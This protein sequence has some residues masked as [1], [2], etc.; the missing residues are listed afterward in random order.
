[1]KNKIAMSFLT[2]GL[3]MSGVCLAGFDEGMGAANRGDYA[4]ALKEW[5]PLADQGNALAQKSLGEMCEN[6]WGV[7]QD[8]AQAAQWY[9][10][11]AEQGNASAQLSLGVMYYKGQGVPKDYAQAGQWYRK[12]ADQGNSNAQYNLGLMYLRGKGVTNDPKQAVYWYE[13]AAEQGDLDAR[14]S[15]ASIYERGEGVP[16]DYD[17]AVEYYNLV[18]KATGLS[19]KYYP[20]EFLR[21]YYPGKV[22][23]YDR[24][25]QELQSFRKPQQFK[26]AVNRW[27]Q[28]QARQQALEEKIKQD[29]RDAKWRARLAQMDQENAA[30]LATINEIR[31]N[32]K[33]K[34]YRQSFKT[35]SACRTFEKQSNAFIVRFEIG[36]QSPDEGRKYLFDM[37][38]SFDECSHSSEFEKSKL[39]D[40]YLSNF[41]GMKLMYSVWDQGV[42]SCIEA[43]NEMVRFTG[44]HFNNCEW[45]KM[46]SSDY[47]HRIV[48][49]GL[50]S[51][52]NG[53]DSLIDREVERHKYR[54]FYGAIS[55]AVWERIVRF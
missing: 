17:K 53:F 45:A 44:S 30:E 20:A 7:S 2:L 42:K 47:S 25:N 9:R 43:D 3:F 55:N 19:G 33:L 15:L 34:K 13:K 26:D 18:V 36:M 49:P 22:E 6:G 37:A 52:V 31:S 54:E 8:Y 11:A 39:R 5:K 35:S 21:K 24:A 50:K 4:T 27:N 29:E 1:M 12:A 28:Q 40:V 16:Q 23:L 41:N 10:K 46:P 14:I 32:L 51:S 38:V 48:V